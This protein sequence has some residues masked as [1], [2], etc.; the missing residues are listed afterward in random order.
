M[1]DFTPNHA[2]A[3]LI[4]RFGSQPIALAAAALFII[5]VGVGSVA[6]WRVYTGT[7]PEQD[8]L[9][10]TRL[11]QARAAQAS[12]QLVE[13]TKALGTS[14]QESIDQLQVVQDQ[15][16]TVKRLLGAQQSETKRLTEQVG[17]LT[18]AIDTLRQSFASAQPADP[19]ATQ[20][21]SAKSRPH[22][23]K[24]RPVGIKPKRPKSQ[25]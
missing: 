2:K 18:A 14:Q 1:S 3:N 25:T 13:K 6:L 22:A 17:S 23:M 24:G 9:A 5:I 20:R 15:L 21:R 10:S 11:M 8:R 7:S 19:P 12:E 16:Q 4:S